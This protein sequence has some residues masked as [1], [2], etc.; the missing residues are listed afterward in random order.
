MMATVPHVISVLGLR[1]FQADGFLLTRVYLLKEIS[2]FIYLFVSSLA[3]TDVTVIDTNLHVVVIHC[4]HV[5]LLRKPYSVAFILCVTCIRSCESCE[6]LQCGDNSSCEE[7]SLLKYGTDKWKVKTWPTTYKIS[8]PWQLDLSHE[9]F[10]PQERAKLYNEIIFLVETSTC[11]I[12][13][14]I[15]RFINKTETG[16]KS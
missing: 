8:S 13:L 6:H 15:I 3:V 1:K 14:R 12:Y 11:Y 16:L 2:I 9:M 7:V 4:I 5:M 10:M